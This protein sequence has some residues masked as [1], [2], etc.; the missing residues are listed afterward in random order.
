MRMSEVTKSTSK[1]HRRMTSQNLSQNGRKVNLEDY[2]EG[3]KVYFYKP[4]SASEAEKRG[5]KAKHMD[6]YAGP[7]RIIKKVGTRSFLI[8]YKGADRWQNKNIS[9]RRW[10]A[11]T[12]TTYSDHV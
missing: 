1:W 6:H 4:P 11:V 8:E 3:T 2:K 9:E 12:H 10:H 5:R 7:A